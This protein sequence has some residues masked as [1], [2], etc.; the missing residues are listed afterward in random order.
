MDCVA[1]AK[2]QCRSTTFSNNI[3]K[4]VTVS[5]RALFCFLSYTFLFGCRILSCLLSYT[6]RWFPS[7]ILVCSRIFYL[8]IWYSTL[9]LLSH[10][11]V[12]YSRKFFSFFSRILYFISP[13]CSILALVYSSRILIPF[14]ARILVP[15]IGFLSYLS[16][17]FSYALPLFLLYILFLLAYVFTLVLLVYSRIICFSRMFYS[18]SR[19]FLSYTHSF[20]RSYTC[21]SNRIPLVSLLVLLVCSSFVSLVYSVFAGICYTLVNIACLFSCYMFFS[22]T[23]LLLLWTPLV[24]SFLFAPV[25]SCIIAIVSL[26]YLLVYTLLLLLSYVEFCLSCARINVFLVYNISF[27]LGLYARIFFFSYAI[28]L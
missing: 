22:S 11:R 8:F 27:L 5:S 28:P 16:F 15:E 25:Y 2:N 14:C 6:L 9:F 10:T 3:L 4:Y 12:F 19:V 20:L 13:V 21:T 7:Y 1:K 24:Y 23:L 26:L 18:C 17:F